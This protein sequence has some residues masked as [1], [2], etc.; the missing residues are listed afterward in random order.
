MNPHIVTFLAI[1]LP[2]RVFGLDMQTVISIVITLF[3][4]ALLAVALTFL[5][6]KPVRKYM[7]N[8]T[9]RIKGQIKS[10][11]EKLAEAEEL[12]CQYE[13]KLKEIE[14]E[15]S[16]MLEAAQKAISEEKTQLLL[17]AEAEAA[18]IIETAR[19]NVA[20]EQERVKEEMKQAIIE[21]STAM[22]EKL[23]TLS[24]DE[25]AHDRLLS[26]TMAELEELA[27]ST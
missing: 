2:E 7:Q 18:A 26:E 27:W 21:V 1:T 24:L 22:A 19:A 5:L 8:R 23:V 9:D 25:T 12:K 11:E 3:N 4:L 10:A 14:A 16:A 6:H 13:Q 20:A 15:R 17:A